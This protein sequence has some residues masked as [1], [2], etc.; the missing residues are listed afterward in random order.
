MLPNLLSL[1]RLPLALLFVFSAPPLRALAIFLAM[2]TDILDG[3]LARRWSHTSRLGT[4]LDPFTD[5]VFVLTVVVF[6]LIE[7]TLTLPQALC[8][9]SRDAALLIFMCYLLFTRR[10]STYIFRPFL[11]GKIATA[12]QFLTLMAL[13]FHTPITLLIWVAF[14]F[15]GITSLIELFWRK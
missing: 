14:L 5:K 2:I 10:W 11:S 8:L 15:L 9:F 13:V 12:L 1:S 3:Y 4:T 6:F 7:G